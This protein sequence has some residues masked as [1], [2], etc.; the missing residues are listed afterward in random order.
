MSDVKNNQVEENPY[1]ALGLRSTAS[2]DE[3]RR[4]YFELVRKYPPERSPEQFKRIRAAYEVLRDPLQRVEWDIFI[5]LQP[6][7][8]FS[9]SPR[10]PK[11]DLALHREDVVWVLRAEIESS[12][13]DF[14]RD[15]RPITPP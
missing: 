12:L 3:I 2:D 13:S 8:P 9:P 4:A 11:P 6:P 10:R 14:Q 1:E 5:A 15:F 7:L